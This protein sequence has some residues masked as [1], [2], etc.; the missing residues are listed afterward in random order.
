MVYNLNWQPNAGN[1]QEYTY[2]CEWMECEWK[3]VHDTI[4][5][6]TA[7]CYPWIDI[8]YE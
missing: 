2:E 4:H 8:K 1:L 5:L 3:H 6:V 7:F